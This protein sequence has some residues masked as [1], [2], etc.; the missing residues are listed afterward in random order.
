[1]QFLFG[2]K[3]K[4]PP[5]S[6]AQPVDAMKDLRS[7]LQILEK[8]ENLMHQRITQATDEAIKKKKAGDTKGK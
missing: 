2:S 7:Q 4:A 3:K 8:R 6:T 1:M 5:V